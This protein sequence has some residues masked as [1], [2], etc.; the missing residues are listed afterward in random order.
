MNMPEV[1]QDALLALQSDKDM[2]VLPTKKCYV[3]VVLL[4]EDYCSK[5]RTVSND[6]IYGKVK[7]NEQ[8]RDTNGFPHEKVRYSRGSC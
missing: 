3:N 7:S 2:K 1:E 4:N 6:T 5:L 8:N